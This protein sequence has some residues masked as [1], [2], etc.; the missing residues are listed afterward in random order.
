MA[1]M[2]QVKKLNHLYPC[3]QGISSADK[4]VIIAIS[5]IPQ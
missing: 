4:S 1:G 2:A 3:L 5:P